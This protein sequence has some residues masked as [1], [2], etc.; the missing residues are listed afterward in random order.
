M[1]LIPTT[2]QYHG[3][4]EATWE[5]GHVV[6]PGVPTRNP[7]ILHFLRGNRRDVPKSTQH[8]TQ[9]AQI[10][11]YHLRC[12]NT[13]V[14][15][16]QSTVIL[17][18]RTKTRVHLYLLIQR[19]TCCW[20][21]LKLVYSSNSTTTS[22]PTHSPLRQ[23]HT[24]REAALVWTIVLLMRTTNLHLPFINTKNCHFSFSTIKSKTVNRC[25]LYSKQVWM[26][27]GGQLVSWIK[28]CWLLSLD[29]TNTNLFSFFFF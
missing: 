26:T 1:L 17:A 14:P 9:G 12:T 28:T 3:N 24:C 22:T 27:I 4:Q 7:C 18:P 13:R 8:L 23:V 19:T 6:L 5:G 11:F 10:L 15:T 2:K 16:I 20:P 29:T 21:K 25:V